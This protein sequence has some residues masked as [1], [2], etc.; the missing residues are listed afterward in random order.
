MARPRFP[1]ARGRIAAVCA[2]VVA[3]GGVV[4]AVSTTRNFVSDL[5]RGAHP[6]DPVRVDAQ[7]APVDAPV[8]VGRSRVVAARSATPTS[9]AGFWYVLPRRVRT[10]PP[11]PSDDSSTW[12]PWARRLGAV[13][14]L[15]TSIRV[16]LTSPAATTVLLDDF[17]VNVVRRRPDY[18]GTAIRPFIGCGVETLRHF[19]VDLGEAPAP[20]LHAV[21]RSEDVGSALPN[22]VLSV[23]AHDPEILLID[24]TLAPWWEA[25]T[26]PRN[27]LVEWTVS[28]RASAGGDHRTVTV[29]DGGRPF[30]TSNLAPGRPS[31]L[32]RERGRWKASHSLAPC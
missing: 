6:A 21:S 7:R 5:W 13:D 25:P 18:A 4:G 2:A 29:D 3:L 31:V 32:V 17:R 20:R 11:P 1:R 22:L 12:G 8:R 30:R 9:G 27:Q 24:A 19:V 26:A 28:F 10:L 16:M 15:T 23:S 14:L